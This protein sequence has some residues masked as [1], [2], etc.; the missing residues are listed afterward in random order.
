MQYGFATFASTLSGLCELCYK[1]RIVKYFF[2][3]VGASAFIRVHLRFAGMT[4]QTEKIISSIFLWSANDACR[5]KLMI[6]KK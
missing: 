6:L 5:S 3:F 2:F 4:R 1:S